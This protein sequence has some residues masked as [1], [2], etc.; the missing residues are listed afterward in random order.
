[1]YEPRIMESLTSLG[2][3]RTVD[4]ALRNTEHQ[5]LNQSPSTPVASVASS[6]LSPALE[7]A[8]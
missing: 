6:K 8:Y 1:M 4:I 5:S 7:G 3:R 2:E